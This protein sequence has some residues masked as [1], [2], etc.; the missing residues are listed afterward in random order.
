MV[1]FGVS[2]DHL[3]KSIQVDGHLFV[4]CLCSE[5]RIAVDLTNNYR[6]NNCRCGFE[7]ESVVFWIPRVEYNSLTDDY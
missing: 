6:C 5:K 2:S 3:G 7:I 1:V 4:S